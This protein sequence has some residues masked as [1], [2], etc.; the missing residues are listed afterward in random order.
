VRRQRSLSTNTLAYRSGRQH[1]LKE[2]SASEVNTGSG[3]TRQTLS[4]AAA[5]S[6]EMSATNLN[7]MTF[8][9]FSSSNA[10]QGL[11]IFDTLSVSSGT[12]LIYG[13]LNTARS[14]LPGDTLVIGAGSL[15][16]TLS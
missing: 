12:L 5:N 14:V 7:P 11:L 9:P 6:P 8:G 15:K 3:Y 16:V 4:M 13:T 1:P 2:N 10:V